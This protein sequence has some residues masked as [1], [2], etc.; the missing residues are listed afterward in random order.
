MCFTAKQTLSTGRDDSSA[1]VATFIAALKFI[2]LN[3][4]VNPLTITSSGGSTRGYNEEKSLT[5]TSLYEGVVYG[6]MIGWEV[7]ATI[8][9]RKAD[10]QQSGLR[11]T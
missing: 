11:D 6:C 3:F 10:G 8:Y 4:I 7:I 1:L 2:I 9:L 5:Q